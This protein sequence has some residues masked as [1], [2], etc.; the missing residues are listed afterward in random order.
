[1]N[2]PDSNFSNNDK[3]T[4]YYM[5]YYKLVPDILEKRM[6]FKDEHMRI[7]KELSSKGLVFVGAEVKEGFPAVF[8]FE[9]KNDEILHEWLRRDPYINNGLVMEHHFNQILL[10]AG[11]IM[12]QAI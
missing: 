9:G 5:L 2:K 3:Q 12:N 7:L 8:M 11:R 4:K 6:P 10:V 1:M